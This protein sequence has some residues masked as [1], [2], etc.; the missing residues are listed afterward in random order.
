MASVLVPVFYIVL[1]VGSLLLFSSFYRKRLAAKHIDPYFPRH[2]ARDTYVTL[3]QRTD[4]PTPDQVLKAALV[5]RAVADVYRVVRLRED[6]PALQALLQKGSIGDDLW[7]SLLA[8]EKELEAEIVEVVS[9][10]N[11]FV[12]GWGQII[13]ETASQV[14]ANEKMRA[15]FENTA[16]VRAEQELLYGPGKRVKAV[17]APSVSTP[18]R[19]STPAATTPVPVNP[20]KNPNGLPQSVADNESVASSDHGGSRSGSPSPSKA[21]SA[22]KNKKRK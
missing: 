18:A 7:N 22:K 1:V 11:T 14:I 10:A 16:Q 6:K 17:A 13:F 19:P 9:E 20:L 12:E 2:H 15:M 8:A 3:L 21:G 4:P 5:N